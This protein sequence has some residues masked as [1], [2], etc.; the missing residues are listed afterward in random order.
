MLKS[1]TRIDK[2]LFAASLALLFVSSYLLYDDS[3]IMN[4]S[5]TKGPVIARVTN[6]ENDVRYKLSQDIQW[7]SKT[8]G[9]EI[10]LGDSLFT[11]PN[12]TATVVLNDNTQIQMRENS[13]IVFNFSGDQLSLGL[14]FGSFTG[15]I[16]KSIKIEGV[17]GQ[18]S[19][20][21]KL[22]FTKTTSKQVI[23][24]VK[25]GTVKITGSGCNNNINGTQVLGKNCSTRAPTSSEIDSTP[26]VIANQIKQTIPEYQKPVIVEPRQIEKKKIV[27]SLEGKPVDD[28]S[29]KVKWDYPKKSKF[30][31]EISNEPDFSKI[32]KS[33]ETDQN[34]YV[35]QNLLEGTH[36]LRVR[37]IPSVDTEKPNWSSPVQLE[38][39]FEKPLVKI[40]IPKP[41][42]NS[43][44]MNYLI[45][46]KKPLQIQWEKMENVKGYLV[47]L[48]E[49]PDLKNSEKVQSETNKIEVSKL[50]PGVTYFQVS[51]I[52]EDEK[53]GPPTQGKIH[54]RVL[55][56]ELQA[57]PAQTYLAKS[58]DD[59]VDPT[60]FELNWTQ[61]PYAEKY[62]V[63][64]SENKN[65]TKAQ[66]YISDTTSKKIQ[67]SKSGNFHWRVRP[68]YSN[69]KVLSDHSKTGSFQYIYKN[70]LKTPLLVEP[71]NK[72]T[73]FF[74]TNMDN[75]FL[76]SWQSVE[77]ATYY[78]LE[79]SKDPE[80]KNI[81]LK[82]KIKSTKLFVKNRLPSGALYWRVR[83]EAPNRQSAWSNVNQL[84]LFAGRLA[85]KNRD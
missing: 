49:S 39:A 10:Y 80:F 44:E 84:K 24:S 41:R 34:Q 66:K 43:S 65:F 64:I 76:L 16:A 25:T 63:Q 1:L 3:L 7:R 11:G 57:I 35:V 28:T 61:V 42:L 17:E 40:E 4:F 83:A 19:G 67:I 53:L 21:G 14:K 8:T 31:V 26:V 2:R 70:P 79:I 56:P 62:E 6:I 9:D 45:S 68:L 75:P 13:L 15:N 47:E 81:L 73:L 30:Q 51:A 48:S 74:Q 71:K 72:M 33:E 82:N 59:K 22:E 77:N 32:E 36:F 69:G 29:F 46:K 78:S 85:E 38:L 60:F 55:P 5:I 18:I 37:E 52:S 27:L 58:S 54:A 20:P 50:K 12:S 23:V